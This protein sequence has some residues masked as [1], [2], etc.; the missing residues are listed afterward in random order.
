MQKK[1]LEKA[2]IN[3]S[4]PQKTNKKELNKL[5]LKALDKWRKR[6]EER[7]GPPKFE[8]GRREN[9]IVLKEEIA[10]KIDPQMMEA[11]GSSDTNFF[12]TMM[13][14]AIGTL[15]TGDS[16]KKANFVAAFMH[17]LKPRDEMEGA[18]VTQMVGT[19]NLIMEYMGRAMVP[20]QTVDGVDANTNRAYKLMNVFLKQVE[21]LNKY[22][23]KMVEQKVTVEHV[24]VHSGGKAIVGHVEGRQTGGGDKD[25]R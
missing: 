1:S 13:S 2:K 20:G 24:H 15:F 25:K 21:A 18:L 19:H 6:K 9:E 4:S 7:V 17:G 5:E 14:Q 3:M 23:G 10:F 8:K 12:F 16:E 11:I 22:R